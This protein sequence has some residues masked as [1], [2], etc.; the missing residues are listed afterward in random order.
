MSKVADTIP[1]F[2]EGIT[3]ICTANSLVI[4]TVMKKA[5][6][7]ASLLLLEATSNQV[8]QF[9]GYTGMVPKDFIKACH[10]IAHRIGLPQEQ[11]LFGGDHL[12]PNPWKKEEAVLA[13]EK[14]CELVRS[15][16]TAGFRKIHLDCSMP[17]KDDRYFSV[18]LASQRAAQLAKVA[19]EAYQTLPSS[20]KGPPP[21]YVV[22][23]E[24]PPPGGSEEEDLRVL[25]T[26]KEDLKEMIRQTKESFYAR[27]LEEAYARIV[28]VVVQPGVEFSD[29]QIHTYDRGAFASLKD[30][31]PSLSGLVFEGHS[32]DYQSKSA[33]RELMEDG[34]RIQKVGP[35]L[36]FALRS[37]LFSLC[38]LASALWGEE[39]TLIKA[40]GEA[41]DEKEEYYLPYYEHL[42]H[43]ERRIARLYGLLDRPRYYYDTKKVQ[44]ERERLLGKL[45][46]IRIPLGLFDQFF[47]SY[48]ERA[49]EGQG[50][51]HPRELLMDCVARVVEGYEEAK[52][53][54][55]M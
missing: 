26:K 49:K 36:T 25:V 29:T 20:H 42:P 17:L 47:P 23:T 9:G 5:K 44:Q 35:A 21:C 45:Q 16:V 34:V 28:A 15:Y 54:G 13:M 48:Y 37:A 3:S 7:N 24:V 14:A 27:D 50:V 46:G 8:N 10:T 32:T 18:E 41:M 2:R 40:Y 12:G 6:E 1:D 53:G 11:I 55:S 38:F 51:F 31:L 30:Y 39:T 52:K 33:L 43:K 19:E 22:G 4:E